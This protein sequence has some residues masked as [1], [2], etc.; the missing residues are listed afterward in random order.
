MDIIWGANIYFV[1]YRI[2]RIFYKY[3]VKHII[4]YVKKRSDCLLDRKIT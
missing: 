3:K 1:I 4:L 2:F